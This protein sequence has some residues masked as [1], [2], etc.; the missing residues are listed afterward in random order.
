MEKCWKMV[1]RSMSFPSTALDTGALCTRSMVCVY[2]WLPDNP[3][4]VCSSPG[5]FAFADRMFVSLSSDA[6]ML[7]IFM[8]GVFLKAFRWYRMPFPH[9]HTWQGNLLRIMLQPPWI[10]LGKFPFINLGQPSD[11][12]PGSYESTCYPG[13]QPLGW[14]N[15]QN[16]M[17]LLIEALD[18]WEHLSAQKSHMEVIFEKKPFFVQDKSY[19]VE[20]S[21]DL[22]LVF[23]TFFALHVAQESR[24][25]ASTAGW[26]SIGWMP[27][28]TTLLLCVV[29]HHVMRGPPH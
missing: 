14:V 25:H 8:L 28:L 13:L 29:P 17:L 6:T 1:S 24:W 4:L 19:P 20:W 2:R 15:T 16:F 26:R 11:P 7:N 21:W 18:K 5:W 9:P 12:E 27:F 3:S 23:M 10:Q 22:L